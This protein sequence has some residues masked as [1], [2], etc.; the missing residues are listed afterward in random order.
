MSGLSGPGLEKL[1]TEVA[2]AVNDFELE[3][4]VH[5]VTGD[6][7]YEEYVGKGLPLKKTIRELLIQLDKDGSLA[8]FLADIL[9][10][11]PDRKDLVAIFAGLVPAAV[12]LDPG[13]GPALS[14]Q[15]AGVDDESATAIAAAPGLQRNVRPHLNMIEVREWL[16][17]LTNA[18]RRVC[19]IEIGKN[20]AGTGFLVGP[21]TV[22]TNW[23]VV[24]KVLD[25]KSW[26]KISCRFDFL[27]LPDGSVQEGVRIVLGDKGVM[28]FSPASDAELTP[29]PDEPPPTGDQLDY[30]LLH[31]AKPLGSQR[32]WVELPGDEIE[33]PAGSP[34]IIAQHPLA[35]PMKLA[36][37]TDSVI[38]RVGRG[39]RLR[40][41]TNTE[42]GSSGSPCF[43]MDWQLVALH[44]LGDPVEGPPVFNQGVPAE[45][46]RADIVEKKKLGA[47]LGADP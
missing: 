25:P 36:L 20:G 27:V 40:Y 37:D 19:R 47:C 32:G 13:A 23:H 15:R 35:A 8:R 18:E 14:L 42:S 4:I 34:L 17:G 31:L 5:V 11:K 9:Q 46:I 26:Q 10:R 28:A 44:H 24:R 3:V 38:G 29:S 6:Q 33:M 43:N 2:G 41:H 12:K 45:L 22:M 7:L 16:D 39:L 30:A 1:T 21:S